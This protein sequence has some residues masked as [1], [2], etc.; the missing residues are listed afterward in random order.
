MALVS[1]GIGIKEADA[2][3][4]FIKQLMILLAQA[5]RDEKKQ[6]YID[7]HM[8]GAKTIL[9]HI[10]SGGKTAYQTVDAG[11]AAVFEKLLQ[12]LRSACCLHISHSC[13]ISTHNRGYT[14]KQ[15]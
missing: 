15:N 6:G 7:E 11:D 3:S 5:I 12:N 9:K 10:K 14:N 1:E 13:K 4:V 2:T 8:K